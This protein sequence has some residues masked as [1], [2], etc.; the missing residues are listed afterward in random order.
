MKKLFAILFLF[1]IAAGSCTKEYQNPTTGN[2][3]GN[4]NG[5]NNGGGN[6]GGGGGGGG[7]SISPVP[8]T[9]TQKVLI[10]EVTGEWCGF[11][12][13]G[14]LK[15]DEAINQFPGKVYAAAIHSDLNGPDPFALHPF[16]ANFETI[17]PPAG[18]P[19][20]MVNRVAVGSSTPFLDR[21][22]GSYCSTQLANVATCG[23]AMLSYTAGSD[24]L[25]VEVHCGFNATMAGNY[26]LTVYL[27]EDDVPAVH[28]SN[29]YDDGSYGPGPLV[30][31]G[32]PIT[33][34]AHKDV[35]RKVLTTEL[36]D[37]IPASKMVPGGEYVVKYGGT[38]TGFVKDNLKIIAFINKV[39]TDA[40]THQIMNVQQSKVSVVK[41][42]D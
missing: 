24:S 31:I 37:V 35:L 32:N 4:N 22:W 34:W 16:D 9:F 5:G 27:V 7:S 2:N 18:Y 21:P 12:P 6:G 3:N 33:T 30:G 41:D 14:L 39:G 28:Q 11:C 25:Y 17:F 36:G 38:W 23:L 1:A 19:Q 8:S 40:V 15:L 20:A 42:W 13:D 10:E 26:H 29:Y